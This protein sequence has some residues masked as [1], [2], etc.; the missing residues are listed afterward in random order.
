MIQSVFN[1]LFVIVSG[2]IVLLGFYSGLGIEL[3]T[4]PQNILDNKLC[5]MFL[6]YIVL[7]E[8]LAGDM[9]TVIIIL[10][11]Y[12]FTSLFFSE[13]KDKYNNIFGT[14]LGPY[15]KETM[16]DLGI[17]DYTHEFNSGDFDI[18]LKKVKLKK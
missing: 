1:Y 6:A 13:S 2:Y 4:F 11:L 8:T 14:T 18:V 10:L 12:Y 3:E 7:H 16:I 9:L 15:V 5:Q 17:E